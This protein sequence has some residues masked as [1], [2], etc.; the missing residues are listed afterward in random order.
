MVPIFPSTLMPPPRDAACFAVTVYGGQLVA[1]EPVQLL[2]LAVSLLYSYTVIPFEATRCL[3]KV[4]PSEVFKERVTDP[5]TLEALVGGVVVPPEGFW[6]DWSGVFVVLVAFVALTGGV[7]WEEEADIHHTY[8]PM[9]TTRTMTTIQIID[10]FF[11][12]F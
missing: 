9:R 4:S 6:P 5:V 7:V 1:H 8:P 2:T 3:S 11:I 12:Y 10:D